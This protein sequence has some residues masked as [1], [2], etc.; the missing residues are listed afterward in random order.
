MA[1]SS[2]EIGKSQ[3]RDDILG[4]ARALMREGGDPGFSMRTLAERAGV[5]IA[6]PYNL[7]GSKQAILLGVLN[8]DLVGYEQALS[9][10]EADAIDVLFESQALVSQLINREPDFYR[11]MIA[12][13]SRDGPEFRHMVSGPRYVLWKRLLGQATAAGLLADD[14]DPDAFAIATSQL[15]LANVLEWAKGAL[16]L[17]EMEARNQYGLALSLLAVAT[18]SS[19]AQIRERFREAERTLQ[20]QWRTALA[21]RLRDGT[22]DEESREILADQIKTLHKE[23][24]ASS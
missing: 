19:R 13:V 17:E 8:A 12:A 9:K 2:R 3:R 5:S 6:T 18:D 15:M 16:T 24:E 11:S 7:F 10:L 4:A 20:S 22:L 1:E 14:I 23:Q 21:K